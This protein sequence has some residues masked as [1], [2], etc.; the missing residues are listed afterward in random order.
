MIVIGY[1]TEAIKEY[2]EQNNA[3]CGADCAYSIMKY[4]SEYYSITNPINE[5]EIRDRCEPL[6]PILKSLSGKR[7]R[8]I[9]RMMRDVC[10]EYGQAAFLNGIRVGAQ[11]IMELVVSQYKIG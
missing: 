8:K 11:L 10:Q 4:L 5:D 6:E 9:L 3:K 7:E 2:I 1:Y